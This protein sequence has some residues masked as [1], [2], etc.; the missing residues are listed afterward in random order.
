MHGEP[1]VNV[2]ET[3][4][5]RPDSQGACTRAPRRAPSRSARAGRRRRGPAA[6][7]LG[8][9]R[10]D[11]PAG[12]RRRGPPQ[13]LRLDRRRHAPH[14]D[15]ARRQRRRGPAARRREGQ[16][17]EA[18]FVTDGEPQVFREFVTRLL[19]TQGVEAPDKLDPARDPAQRSRPA[20]EAAWRVL[21]LP[22]PAA[23]DPARRSGSPRRSARSTSRAPAASLGYTPVTSVDDGY[24]GAAKHM[25]IAVG[26]DHAGFHLK[27]H[28]RQV[29][30]AEGHEI[31]D[32]G[33]RLARLRRLPALRRGGQ[34][35]RRRGGCR[36][37]RPRLR[38]GRRRRD[39][40]QQ[41]RRRPRRQR[42]RRL[43]GRDG[44]PPQRRQRGDAAAARGS[45]PE[46][47][48]RIVSAFLRTGFEGGRH[49]RRVGQI[50]DVERG[51]ASVVPSGSA[52]ATGA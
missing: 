13:A 3:A 10:H 42:A 44:P 18:Y 11:D 33:D 38:V 41:G 48:D 47:A 1:L 32:V 12:A 2:D 52:A 37:R 50:A 40:R 6:A 26:S 19:A 5:L 39:R 25:R 43:G 24:G 35:P 14:V 21:P 8:P 36:S 16:A 20:G 51:R 23:G 15:H 31:V 46:Q 28:V 22:G 9:G 17:G 29:L 27:E 34:P 30:E 7:R 49:A 45:Q 4:P